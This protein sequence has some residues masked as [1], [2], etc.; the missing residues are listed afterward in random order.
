MRKFLRF[1]ITLVLIALLSILVLGIIQPKDAFVT[2][3][4]FIKAPKDSIFE[5]IVK[6]KNWPHWSPWS[7]KDTTMKI[8][9]T[10]TD[11][12]PGSSYHWIGNK[13]LT[14]EG[15]MKNMA[16]DGTKMDYEINI[17]K[18]WEMTATGS[19]IVKD[20]A[21]GMEKVT[22]TF[23]KHTPFPWNAMN[24]FVNIDKYMG[25]DFELGLGTMKKYLEGR[26]MQ[27]PELEIKEVDFPEH[28]YQ[29]VRKTISW[30]DITKFFMD[31]KAILGKE[32]MVSGSYSGLYYTWDTAT[33][34]TDAVAGIPVS[35]TSMQVEG[36]SFFHV[37]AA[38]AYMTVHK[39]GYSNMM[40]AHMAIA[41][42]MEAK[43]QKHSLVIEEY[44][45]GQYNQP[46]STKWVTNIY[47][48]VQQ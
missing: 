3:S 35:D 13:D 30:M 42:Q 38:R 19:L 22:W 16:V 26:A 7:Q 24:M 6:F 2:R 40:A 10:G 17:I 43:G 14:G 32:T 21:N 5:E 4:V 25:G 11:G 20:T 12:T 31:N 39:G 1:V 34:T 29:G 41:K 9:Y 46:D 36:A 47:Y 18:P 48:L 27:A 8:T 44:P 37:P 15:E 23:I 28:I 45:S 33:K